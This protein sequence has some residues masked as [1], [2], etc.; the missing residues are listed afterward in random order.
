[1]VHG[2][3]LSPSTIN[4]MP[5]ATSHDE[6]TTSHVNLQARSSIEM[7]MRYLITVLLVLQA[8]SGRAQSTDIRGTWTAELR[9]AKVFLQLRTA[10]PAE[11]NGDRWNG[12]WTM[13]QTFPVEAFGGLPAND[14]QFSV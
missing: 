11:W 8:V 6:L 12:D 9:D 14:P 13:G 10:P 4:H 1:M 7:G 5:L 2:R 3:W